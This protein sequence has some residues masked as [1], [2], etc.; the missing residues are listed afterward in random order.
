[1]TRPVF[2][3]CVALLVLSGTHVTATQPRDGWHR[4][5]DAWE[6]TRAGH[7]GG[8]VRVNVNQDPGGT[9]MYAARFTATGDLAFVTVLTF[10]GRD[11]NGIT[12]EWRQGTATEAMNAAYKRGLAAHAGRRS[13]ALNYR[14]VALE[15]ALTDVSVS[16]LTR[17]TLRIESR[18]ARLT[19]DVGGGIPAAYLQLGPAADSSVNATFVLS[20]GKA[21]R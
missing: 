9:L 4:S 7:V 17:E 13:E 10:V 12:V 3:L 14:S 11:D 1:M 19:I 15:D 6:F 2:R 16:Q 5:A 8:L 21:R 20:G 18:S